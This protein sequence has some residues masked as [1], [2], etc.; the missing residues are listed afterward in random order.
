MLIYN[1]Q[2]EFIGIDEKDLKALG[3]QDL[4]ALRMEVTDFADLFVKTPGY[5]HN[6]KHVHWI[7]FITCADSNEESKVI[8]NV[9]NK[10]FTSVIQI[11]SAFLI[12]NPSSKA[13][14]ITLNHLREL[15]HQ[16]SEK[17]AGDIIERQVPVATAEKK[18]IFNA[19]EYD[20]AFVEPEAFEEPTTTLTDDPYAAPLE[21]DMDDSDDVMIDFQDETFSTP[22]E[23]ASEVNSFME[24]TKDDQ[25]LEITMDENLDDALDISFEDD[26]IEDEFQPQQPDV[27]EVQTTTKI[28]V[29]DFDNGYVYDP[30][31]ASNE[32]GLPL[33]LI[34]EFIQD[35]IIQ[36]KEFKENL[37]R[38]LDENDLDNLKILSHK[39]KGVAANLRIEDALEALTIIN[40]SSDLNVIKENLDTLYKIIAKLAGEEVKK[41]VEVPIEE[42]T[43]PEAQELTIPEEVEEAPAEDDLLSLDF[44]EDED[45]LYS[46]PAEL[47]IEDSHVP[48]KIEI[49]ELADDTFITEEQTLDIEEELTLDFKETPEMQELDEEITLEIEEEQEEEIALSLEDDFEEII[50]ESEESLHELVEEKTEEPI[51]E[52]PTYSKESVAKEIGIDQESFNELFNDY[53]TEVKLIQTTIS[54]ALEN[55]DFTTVHREALKLKGMSD[56]MRVDAFKAEVEQLTHT[57]SKEETVAALQKVAAVI[58]KLSKTEV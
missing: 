36:A 58:E 32:L 24:D 23:P 34:E 43:Q 50:E 26:L 29:E 14:L 46:D 45:D 57:N 22:E 16:E 27:K 52:I 25:P 18:P 37:Y 13:Y 2:K 38:S 49:A 44:K 42:E 47:T 56:N 11:S 5:I 9:N 8:I 6:F 7:D 1:F 41:E 20:D 19:P 21:I 35:F 28:V 15:T 39:L 30:S 10:N 55:E 51:I 4:A 53:L 12:D 48:E 31:V 3:F 17:I 54:Q 40:T 33:D